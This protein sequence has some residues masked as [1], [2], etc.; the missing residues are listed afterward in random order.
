MQLLT[1]AS[2]LNAKYLFLTDSGTNSLRYFNAEDYGFFKILPGEGEL[3]IYLRKDECGEY[4]MYRVNFRETP[5]GL[6]IICPTYFSVNK[7]KYWTHASAKTRR[8]FECRLR[9]SSNR[10]L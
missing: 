2:E 5:D 8:R 7:D 4:C 3:K 9:A 1:L 6:V 10:L